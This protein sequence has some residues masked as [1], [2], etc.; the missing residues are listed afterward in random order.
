[1]GLSPSDIEWECFEAYKWGQVSVLWDHK[2]WHLTEKLSDLPQFLE[3]WDE[4]WKNLTE[5]QKAI[6]VKWFEDEGM[7]DG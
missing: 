3:F 1:M 6:A 2:S 5:E 7:L 4:S